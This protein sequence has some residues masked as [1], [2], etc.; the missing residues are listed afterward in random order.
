MLDVPEYRKRWYSSYDDYYWDNFDKNK[1]DYFDDYYDV[2]ADYDDYWW[3]YG[4]ADFRDDFYDDHYWEY[5]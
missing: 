1:A 3:N 5:F 4:F 2:Y